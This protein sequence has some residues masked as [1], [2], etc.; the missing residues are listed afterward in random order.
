MVLAAAVVFNCVALL[1][2]PLR[3]E[4]GAFRISLM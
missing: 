1:K 4:P 2:N 3:M